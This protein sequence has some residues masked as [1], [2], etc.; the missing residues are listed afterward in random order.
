MTMQQWFSSLYFD[1]IPIETNELENEANL[2][3]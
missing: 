3:I 2:D 1:E